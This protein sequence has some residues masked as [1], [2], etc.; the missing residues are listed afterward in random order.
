MHAYLI[1]TLNGFAY[2]LL[3]FTIAA[4]LTLS[5]GVANVLNLA[6]GTTFLAGGYIGVVL[7]DGSWS[8]LLLGVLAGAAVG[9]AA[10]GVLSVAAR[11]LYGRGHLS[12]AMLTFGLALLGGYALIEIFGAQEMRAVIPAALDGTV[13]VWGKTYP[14]YR[15]GFIGVAALLAIVGWWIL[16]RTSIGARVRATVDDAGM[17]SSLGINPRLVM[18][19]VLVVAGLLAGVGGV[20]GGPILGLGTG[21]AHQVLLLS[22]VIVVLGQAGSLRGALLASLFVGLVQNLGIALFP[23]AA[24][25]LLFAAMAVVLIV[26]R[27]KALG[28]NERHPDRPVTA[29]ASRPY[30]VW[31]GF[32]VVVP[33]L[34]LAPQ[35]FDDFAL[36]QLNRVAALGLLAVSIALLAGYCGLATLGQTAPFAVGAYVTFQLAEAGIAV[37]PVQLAIVI[38]ACAVFSLAT[39]PLVLRTRGMVFLMVTLAVGMV[40]AQIAEQ[41][42]SVTGGT[43]GSG[44]INASLPWWGADPLVDDGDIYWYVLSVG[45]LV[46][47]ATVAVTRGA[48]GTR[49]RGVRDNEL[50][51]RAL[52]HRVPGYLLAAYVG[53]GVIAGVG[54]S[55]F[56]TGQRFVFP[57]DVGF[58]VAAIALLAALIG[59]IHSAAGAVVGVV[60]VIAVRYWLAPEGH[61]ELWL[62]VLFV[63][64]VYLLPHGITGRVAHLRRAW[65]G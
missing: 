50:R 14:V 54:G 53:A 56:A 15:L 36:S 43:D 45:A 47:F 32:A 44:L 37:G 13:E 6:H 62:G 21:T 11:P 28:V 24:S 9:M 64:A 25:Y 10:G 2:G 58:E 29:A 60:V 23:A 12:Q 4:G 61:G 5:L 51:M 46:L 27:G 42:T 3:L 17:V 22:L 63:A 52:G 16:S 30:L 7:S 41:W 19:G 1:P 48:A 55:L 35:L 40:T 49:L 8:G 59:G 34:Y 57:A 65:S 39:G 18:A 26:R 38:V 31:V 20:L 33:L